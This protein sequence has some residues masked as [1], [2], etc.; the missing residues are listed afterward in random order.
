MNRRQASIKL[1][2][3]AY[4]DDKTNRGIFTISTYESFWYFLNSKR[5]ITRGVEKVTPK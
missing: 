3:Q 4:L 2:R 1:R 5:C